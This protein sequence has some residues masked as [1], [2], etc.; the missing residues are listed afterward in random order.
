MYSY[1]VWAK[2]F[3]RKLSTM[4]G[5]V[6]AHEEASADDVGGDVRLLCDGIH[7]PVLVK[8]IL[9]ENPTPP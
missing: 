3:P 5:Q 2:K 1:S 7:V 9:V 4:P 8:G 6:I